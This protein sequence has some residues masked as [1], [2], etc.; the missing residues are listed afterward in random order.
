MALNN[1]PEVC[2]SFN[3]FAFNRLGSKGKTHH[4][5]DEYLPR[6]ERV[7][8][9]KKAFSFIERILDFNP[10]ATEQIDVREK[11]LRSVYYFGKPSQEKSTESGKNILAI[12]AQVIT[13][14]QEPYPQVVRN[15]FDDLDR[16]FENLTQ[17]MDILSTR[18]LSRL[19]EYIPAISTPLRRYFRR[20]DQRKTELMRILQH[21]DTLSSTIQENR[22]V[23]ATQ[24]ESVEALTKSIYKALYLGKTLESGLCLARDRHVPKDDPRHA[25]IS[26]EILPRLSEKTD[27][28]ALHMKIHSKSRLI[29][30]LFNRSCLETVK[31][32]DRIREETIS[33]YQ[34]A[35]LN[36]RILTHRKIIKG[37]LLLS[38][39]PFRQKDMDFLM[40]PSLNP[41]RE[42]LESLHACSGGLSSFMVETNAAVMQAYLNMKRLKKIADQTRE[43]TLCPFEPD[44]MDMFYEYY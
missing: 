8:L 38:S 24:I 23:L 17:G 41:V 20:F 28:L 37:D 33:T 12:C 18:G 30:E 16:T 25:F 32:L 36:A 1:V 39:N 10:D 31:R 9:D 21:V 13:F 26:D 35:A 11:H 34:T 40:E 27:A 2:L 15:L 7:Y 6:P 14:Y 22:T 29:L 4:S 43:K 3:D 44:L 42:A 19:L 5:P